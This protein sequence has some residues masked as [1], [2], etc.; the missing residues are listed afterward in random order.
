MYLSF[1]GTHD[2]KQGGGAAVDDLDAGWDDEDEG[3]SSDDLDAGWDDAG[4]SVAAAKGQASESSPPEEEEPEE[5]LPP[6]RPDA[7]PEERAARARELAARVEARKQRARAAAIAKKEKRK[8][9]ADAAAAKRKPKQKAKPKRRDVSRERPSREVQDE[10]PRSERRP[11]HAASTAPTPQ[12]RARSD[13]S[14]KVIGALI[15]VL[16]AMGAAVLWLRR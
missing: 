15:A 10:A 3:E 11:V 4:E 9:R 7:T 16:L 14:V 8:A 6:E 5:P 12:A 2:T 1:V 13:R